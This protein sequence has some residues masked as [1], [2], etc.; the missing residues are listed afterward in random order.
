MLAAR[1]HLTLAEAIA[2]QSRR[3]LCRSLLFEG[4]KLVEGQNQ[5]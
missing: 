3:V 1:R 5:R 4:G 2:E